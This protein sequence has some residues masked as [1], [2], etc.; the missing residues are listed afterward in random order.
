[1]AH[2]GHFVRILAQPHVIERRVQVVHF[3]RRP[4]AGTVLR[5]HCVQRGDDP[6][7]PGGILTQCM[8]QRAAVGDEFGQPLF[9]RAERI[10]LI[11]TESIA[12]RFGTVAEAVPDFALG[13]LFAAE[14]NR[15]LIL[16]A[17]QDDDRFRLGKAREIPEVAVETVGVVG[18]AVA[19]AF[20]AQPG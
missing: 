2:A 12:C 13:I 9:E 4:L 16:A 10:G 3:S 14:Q 17:D 6:G 8:P 1:M 7:I 5:A 20:G 15:F 19:Q 18:V 11:K